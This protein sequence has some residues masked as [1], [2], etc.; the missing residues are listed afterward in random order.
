MRSYDENLAA[1]LARDGVKQTVSF[2]GAIRNMDMGEPLAEGDIIHIPEDFTGKIF[3]APVGATT[4]KVGYMILEITR[5]G[6]EERESFR[7]YPNM[8]AKVVYP[9]DS[10]RGVRLP[11]VKT[12][13]TACEEFCKHAT[14]QEGMEALKGRNILVS[15][16]T[17]Y[18]TWRYG[19]KEVVDTHCYQYDFV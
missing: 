17:V 3:E 1:E 4:V 15:K 16:D 9:V 6:S 5:K 13:G 11:K 10:E 2:K 19:T 14:I 7:F 18:P 8:L 12:T